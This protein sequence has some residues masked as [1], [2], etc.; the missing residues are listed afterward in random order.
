MSLSVFGSWVIT[1]AF[2]FVLFL[3]G[4]LFQYRE[5][6]EKITKKSNEAIR[7]DLRSDLDFYGKR[8]DSS[9]LG[10]IYGRPTQYERRQ[11]AR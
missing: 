9:T 6:Q 8:W 2:F 7:A 11:S 10:T 4:K 5:R 1:L 3:V